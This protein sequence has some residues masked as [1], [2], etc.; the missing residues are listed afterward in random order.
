MFSHPGIKVKES[1]SVTSNIAVATHIA[2]NF[3]RVDFFFQSESLKRNNVISQH[4]DLK[5]AFSLQYSKFSS[6]VRL[7]RVFKSRE[8]LRKY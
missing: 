2:I 6:V 4:L 7:S 8:V 5:I 3:S 1:F